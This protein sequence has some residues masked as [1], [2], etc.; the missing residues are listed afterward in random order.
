MIEP[1]EDGF[2]PWA[3]IDDEIEYD[4]DVETE[5]EAGI[6]AVVGSATRAAVEV[7]VRTASMS[8]WE[9]L[10]CPVLPELNEED[11]DAPSFVELYEE[12]LR[13]IF[14]DQDESVLEWISR[15]EVAER[16]VWEVDGE[17]EGGEEEGD[18]EG[19]AGEDAEKPWYEGLTLDE[20]FDEVNTR[21]PYPR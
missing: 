15:F 16:P 6:E 2:D 1:D 8:E 12:G 14:E 13:R 7:A 18:G 11:L 5:V 3:E 21:C 17:G 10:G 19:E 4:S 20:H 9:A